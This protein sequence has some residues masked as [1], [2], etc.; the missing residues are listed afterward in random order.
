MLTE[1]TNLST[2]LEKL[3]RITGLNFIWHFVNME[4]KKEISSPQNGHYCTF[5]RRIK[6][7]YSG[8]LLKRCIKEH[9]SDEFFQSLKQR[10]PFVIHCHAGAMELVIPLIVN[11]VFCGVL[12]V[13]TFRSPQKYGYN[14][15]IGEWQKLPEIKDKDLLQ[16]GDFLNTLIKKYLD[17]QNM[18]P[19]G[20]TPLIPQVLTQDIRILRAVKLIRRNFARPVKVEEAAQLANLSKAHF[21][22]LF[23]NETGFSFSDFLQRVRVNSARSLVEGSDMPLSEIAER[24]GIQDQSRMGVL[25]R[26]YFNMSPREMRKHYRRQ[27][28]ELQPDTGDL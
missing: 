7:E 4:W 17:N 12:C 26:R 25:F 8:E 1:L 18:I 11:E 15:F 14:E 20:T 5:C 21:T 9:H 27:I 28:L 10:S 6:S 13:G 23:T 22:H 2:A 3:S 19:D 24:C 16:W